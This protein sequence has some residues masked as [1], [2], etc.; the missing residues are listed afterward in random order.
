ME[1][2]TRCFATLRQGC[3]GFIAQHNWPLWGNERIT[4]FVSDQRDIYKYIHDETLRLANHGYTLF[5]IPELIK[6]P[7]SLAK[8]WYNRSYYGSVH[9]NSKAVY[10]RYLGWWEGNPTTFYA[11]PPQEF[12][13]RF[14]E[15]AG[16]SENILNHLEVSF[17][18]GDFRWVAE[19]AG[20][21][22]F[23]EPNN[24]VAREIGAK[25]L[26]QLGLQQENTTWRNTFLTGAQE[27]R[28]GKPVVPVDPGANLDIVGAIPP[29]LLL[30][31]F[32][33]RLN[34]PKAAEHSWV[35]GWVVPDV[36]QAFAI[37]LRNGVLVYSKVP[38]TGVVS[39]GG[40]IE[41]WRMLF[42][43]LTDSIDPLFNLVEP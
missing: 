16:G 38:F 31:Y 18:Q 23:A 41:A 22:V 43:E 14:V 24:L 29:E 9:H 7:D 25:A 5:E 34:G 15:L 20:K 28:N 6:V 42:E 1:D 37:E 10:Q 8:Q 2:L 19:V 32:G 39:V 26:E 40:E 33:I 21:V 35:L 12:A 30:D 36:K 4:K 3:R 27:L 11:L 17:A 13:T